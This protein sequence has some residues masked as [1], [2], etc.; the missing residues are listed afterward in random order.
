MSTVIRW[1]PVREM[2]AMQS[3]I[4]RLFDD[5]WRIVRPTAGT[6]ALPLDVYETDT[7]YIVYS[8]VPGTDPDQ[9]K[10]SLDDDV[11]TISAEI[12]KPTIDEKENARVLAVERGY[13]K[14]NRSVRLG[15]PVDS[16]KIE[17]AYEN[18]VLKLTLPKA[19]QVQPKQIRVRTTNGQPS[20]N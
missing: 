15:L 16:D 14:F 3:A 19:A 12:S 9:I 18:G 4:D 6:N 7:A 1:N 10:I 20:E 8:T 17:A 13:G 2:A 5:S 11:L